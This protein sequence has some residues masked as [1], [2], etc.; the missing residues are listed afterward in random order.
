MSTADARQ[1]CG[2]TGERLGKTKLPSGK[3][4]IHFPAV[5]NWC[6]LVITASFGTLRFSPSLGQGNPGC[7]EAGQRWGTIVGVQRSLPA[8][9]GHPLLPCAQ[10][11]RV[12]HDPPTE[13]DRVGAV[14]AVVEMMHQ[15]SEGVRARLAK[16]RHVECVIRRRLGVE[17]AR[18]ALHQA[19]IHPQEVARVGG[20]V[21][22]G[23][24]RRSRQVEGFA[25][26]SIN[27]FSG[28]SRIR[29]IM[30]P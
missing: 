24:F 15:D 21:Q 22:R 16:A 29:Q 1:S 8:Q 14:C 13:R 5:S 9:G 25:E 20:E 28:G 26:D 7:S 11:R 23:G 17:P 2:Q 3:A 10:A 12:A 27:L 18:P 19:A 6:Q 4:V 30:A